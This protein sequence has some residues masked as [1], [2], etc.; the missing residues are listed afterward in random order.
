MGTNTSKG[1]MAWNVILSLLLALANGM[2]VWVLKST[3]QTKEQ[4][5][6]L[7]YTVDLSRVERDHQIKELREVVERSVRGNW[8]AQSMLRYSFE[9]GAIN[10]TLR[11]PDVLKIARQE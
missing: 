11:T 10:P 8:T 5:A 1:T 3:L 4:L 9:L 6:Q 2:G 7:T